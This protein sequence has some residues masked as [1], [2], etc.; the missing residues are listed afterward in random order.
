MNRGQVGRKRHH[1]DAGDVVLEELA[2]VPSSKR[3]LELAFA[4]V[5]RREQGPAPARGV[6]NGVVTVFDCDTR[7]QMCGLVSGVERRDV[8]SQR[9]GNETVEDVAQNFVMYLFGIERI[10]LLDCVLNQREMFL[11][12]GARN[13]EAKDWGVINFED[14]IEVLGQLR[15]RR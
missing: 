14:S 11:A 12:V 13:G 3:F 6:E 7:E 2:M 4:T 10:N 9:V 1:V 15:W 5:R 8:L